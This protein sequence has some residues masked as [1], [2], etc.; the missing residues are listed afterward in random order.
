[1]VSAMPTVHLDKT[2]LCLV[3]EQRRTLLNTSGVPTYHT[4]T[5]CE[6]QGDVS[7]VHMDRNC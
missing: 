5:P 4:S 2:V 1:M 3:R 6:L 7:Y